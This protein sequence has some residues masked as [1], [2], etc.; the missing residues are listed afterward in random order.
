M[1]QRTD[2]IIV[3]PLDQSRIGEVYAIETLC[4]P[5]PW[6]KASLV[7]AYENGM[8]SF[9]AAIDSITGKL[10]GYGGIYTVCDSADITAV[11][12]LPEY[13]GRGIGS[14]LIGALIRDAI[15][16]CAEAIH[17]EVRESNI[18]AISLY[19]K[20]GFVADGRRRGYYRSPKEDAILM[21]LYPNKD[22]LI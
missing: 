5:E 12:V 15:R 10:C 14:V 2:G 1:E 18:P 16:R 13:R 6:S 3:I 4:I 11:A 20:H 9:Y 7:S 8:Y 21:T 17:L 22:S 19:K